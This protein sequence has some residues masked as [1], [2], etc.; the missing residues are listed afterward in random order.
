MALLTA[1]IPL[2]LVCGWNGMLSSLGH[3]QRDAR[4]IAGPAQ[5]VTFPLRSG[6]VYRVYWKPSPD[7]RS[8]SC[9]LDPSLPEGVSEFR[10]GSWG[11]LARAVSD[12]P[13]GVV[14]DGER[15]RFADQVQLQLKD[16][17]VLDTTVSCDDG[18]V[19]VEAASQTVRVMSV[20]ELVA[21]VVLPAAVVAS[22]WWLWWRRRRRAVPSTSDGALPP[23]SS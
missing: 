10:M 19:L 1:L 2:V 3:F 18:P 17:D 14:F 6:V 8:Q 7:A 13:D 9:R 16:R 15:Y 21:Y 4:P 5:L 22:G 12:T 11:S 20:V 23:S